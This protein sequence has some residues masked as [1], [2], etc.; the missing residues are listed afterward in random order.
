MLEVLTT[1]QH[2]EWNDIVKTFNNWEVYFLCEYAISLE[3]HGDGRALLFY[4]KNNNT[5]YNKSKT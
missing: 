2:K 5:S 1:K 4:F 3:M